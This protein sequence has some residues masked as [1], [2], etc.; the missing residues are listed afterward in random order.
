MKRARP[1]V[2]HGTLDIPGCTPGAR[3]IIRA[4]PDELFEGTASQ[5]V[6]WD[7]R[8][9]VPAARPLVQAILHDTHRPGSES[10]ANEAAWQYLSGGPRAVRNPKALD[11]MFTRL[12][13]SELGIV[14]LP[15]D[16]VRLFRVSCKDEDDSAIGNSSEEEAEDNQ[17]SEE[18][19]EPV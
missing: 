14:R 12:S 2:V 16:A 6:L 19:A 3:L 8:R 1:D 7:P 18:A 10:D 5:A 11:A 9:C 13:R 4:S 17:C 15:V